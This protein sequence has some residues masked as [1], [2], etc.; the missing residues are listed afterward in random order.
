MNNVHLD[1]LLDSCILYLFSTGFYEVMIGPWTRGAIN[2][3]K[4]DKRR[5]IVCTDMCTNLIHFY[6][7]NNA[8][9]R[10]KIVVCLS[11]LKNFCDVSCV[12]HE[13]EN[14]SPFKKL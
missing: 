11:C 7:C 5:Y 12:T 9:I 1:Q 8:S 14:E 13:I 3:T 10:L 4:Q 6:N 2:L